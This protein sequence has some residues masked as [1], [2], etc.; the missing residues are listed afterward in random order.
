MFIECSIFWCVCF[1]TTL[2][3]GK[4][5]EEEEQSMMKVFAQC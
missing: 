2:R 4:G 3:K 1:D 5:V